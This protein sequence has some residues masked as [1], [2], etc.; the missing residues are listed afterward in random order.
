MSPTE[1]RIDPRITLAE[2][3]EICERHGLTVLVDAHVNAD[4]SIVP[5]TLPRRRTDSGPDFVPAFIRRK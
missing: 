5:L 1:I 3:A 4:G 2:L